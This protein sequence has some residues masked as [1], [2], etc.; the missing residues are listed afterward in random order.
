MKFGSNNELK[1][2]S[3][4]VAA[5]A[6]HPDLGVNAIT[7]LL[8]TLYEVFDNYGVHY[9]M[10]DF[11]NKFINSDLNG[12]LLG[13]N[14]PDESGTLTLNV[15][16]ISLENNKIKIGMN[17]RIPIKTPIS[18]VENIFL[19][20]ITSFNTS[21]S[22]INALHVSFSDQKDSLYIPK[23]NRLIKTLCGIYNEVTNQNEQPIAI[24]GATY[25]RAFAN[26]VSFGATMPNTQDL[27][28][29]A[30]EHID[31]DTLIISCKIYAKAI[32]EL[33]KD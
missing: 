17:L 4:G 2:I 3:T 25:A 24:G 29:Q 33:S 23:D 32:Y 6:A 15:A 28:H 18:S 11:F 10:L 22:E 1:L 14:F 7:N 21:Y 9:S 20:K 31:I 5:H 13:I 26:T 27:C 30:N 19:D 16:Q 8:I 12:G